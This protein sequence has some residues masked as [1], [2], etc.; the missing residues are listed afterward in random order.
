MK[1]LT[2]WGDLLED[3]RAKNW[4]Y[5]LVSSEMEC[6]VV[7]LLPYLRGLKAAAVLCVNTTEPLELIK[8]NPEAVYELE[9]STDTSQGI[10]NAIKVALEG[11]IAWSKK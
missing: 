9:E 7:F 11:G 1:N 4:A 3:P 2:K 10:E 8:E 6:S 5:P